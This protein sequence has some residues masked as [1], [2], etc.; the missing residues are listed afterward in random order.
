VHKYST[1]G[2]PHR[3]KQPHNDTK[4]HRYRVPQPFIKEI[5]VAN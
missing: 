2:S 1:G 3:S 4:L 5:L